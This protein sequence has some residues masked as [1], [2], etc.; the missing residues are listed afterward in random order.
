MPRKSRLLKKILVATLVLAYPVAAKN[1]MPQE[2]ICRLPTDSGAVDP[3]VLL[4]LCATL[5][6]SLDAKILFDQAPN[7]AENSVDRTIY[8]LDISVRSAS[9]LKI[10][11]A[12]GSTQ[13]WRT[14]TEVRY[15]D[16][17]FDVMDGA[18]NETT[19]GP[20][21]DTLINLTADQK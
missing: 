17:G 3:K 18:I 1:T 14:A 19:I 2:L 5:S 13:A 11:Y 20:L 7:L 12:F 9:A 6:H 8:V 16:L 4:E 21:A 15:D 10:V